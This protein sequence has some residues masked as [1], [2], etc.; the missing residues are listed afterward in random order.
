MPSPSPSA[1]LRT[2]TSYQV[3][4][5]QSCAAGVVAGVQALP[6]AGVA[7]CRPSAWPAGGRRDA[8][9]RE[10]GVRA[11][12]GA[13][14]GQDDGEGQGERVAAAAHGHAVEG[15]VG[16]RAPARGPYTARHA[17]P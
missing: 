2:K 12:A 1:K 5:F 4:W 14:G 11:V 13:A 15:D 17:Q 16:G 8:A 9:T 6:G 3:R 10:A 7:G